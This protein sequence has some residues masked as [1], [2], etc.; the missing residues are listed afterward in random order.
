MTQEEKIFIEQILDRISDAIILEPSIDVNP[1]FIKDNQ[2]TVRDGII[3][4]GR[5]NEETLLLY[6]KDIEANEQDLLDTSAEYNKNFI[7][8]CKN[9]MSHGIGVEQ[10]TIQVNPLPDNENL[11]QIILRSTS[12]ELEYDVTALLSKIN[13]DGTRNPVNVSQF[14]HV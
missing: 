4:H 1:Q 5:S 2:K 13:D 14:M 11:A 12:A 6:Q 10:I 7:D 3:R 9:F 8:I